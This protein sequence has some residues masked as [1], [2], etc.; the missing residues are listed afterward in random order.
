MAPALTYISGTGL[1]FFKHTPEN[2]NSSQSELLAIVLVIT[3]WKGS[4]QEIF[5]KTYGMTDDASL[6]EIQGQVN[7]PSLED[8][9]KCGKCTNHS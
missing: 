2:S 9:Q 7:P 6:Q 5:K 4:S 1:H 8:I 3:K